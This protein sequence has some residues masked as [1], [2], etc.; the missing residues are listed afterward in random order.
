[1][2]CTLS[3][4]TNKLDSQTKTVIFSYTCLSLYISPP[5]LVCLFLL[6]VIPGIFSNDQAQCV[7]GIF[8]PRDAP[9]QNVY[10]QNSTREV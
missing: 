9:E 2:G 3:S 8:S 10:T 4:S 7:N 5:L 1:M 6:A